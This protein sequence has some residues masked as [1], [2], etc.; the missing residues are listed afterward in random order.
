MI[1]DFNRVLVVG[2]ATGMM[3]VTALRYTTSVVVMQASRT[4]LTGVVPCAYLNMFVHPF[5]LAVL[6]D[7]GVKTCGIRTFELSCVRQ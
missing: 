1:H 7:N 3:D 6:I 4:A 2:C 5:L